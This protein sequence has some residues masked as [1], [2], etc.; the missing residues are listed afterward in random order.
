VVEE[1][2][3]NLDAKFWTKAFAQMRSAQPA[4][5]EAREKLDRQ[6]E[7]LESERQRLLRLC[8]K[9]TIAEED[10]GRESKRIAAEVRDLDLLAPAPVPDAVD[11]KQT[12]AHL[13]RTFARFGRQPFEG[14][15]AALRTVFKDLVLDNGAVTGFTVNSAFLDRANSSPRCSAW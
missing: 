8:L 4:R 7:K 14:K 9:G 6:C 1:F 2:V 12:A 13:A 3:S 5:D 10:F 15:R 11:P